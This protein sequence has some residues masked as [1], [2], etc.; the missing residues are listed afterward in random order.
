MLFECECVLACSREGAT[1]LLLLVVW[2]KDRR[3]IDE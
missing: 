3:E 1:S 2:C